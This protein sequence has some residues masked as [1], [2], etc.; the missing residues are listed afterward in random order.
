MTNRKLIA[1]CDIAAMLVLVSCTGTEED[2]A[3][4]IGDWRL[5]SIRTEIRDY[6][7]PP[8]EDNQ[9]NSDVFYAFNADS[10][11]EIYDGDYDVLGTWTF[12][13]SILTM[14]P[15]DTTEN[16]VTT[17]RV[18]KLRGDSLIHE[19]ESESDFGH[20]LEYMTFVKVK[21]GNR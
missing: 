3:S 14:T 16:P 9:F 1:I 6:P 2:E 10:T 8:G 19:S 20:I 17:V 18:V 7:D 12:S 21:N 11:Y 13:D 15:N 4:I 5:C